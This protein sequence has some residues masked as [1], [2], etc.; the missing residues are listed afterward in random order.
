MLLLSLNNGQFGFLVAVAAVAGYLVYTRGKES[1]DPTSRENVFYQ[2]VNAVGD[3]L[4]DGDPSNDNF[5]LGRWIFFA[6]HPQVNEE[7]F[8]RELRK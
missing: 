5:N 3:V 7:Q 8:E 2:G 4:N 6:T 1:L